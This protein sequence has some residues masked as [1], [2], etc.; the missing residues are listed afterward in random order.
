[1]LQSDRKRDDV[2]VA[3]GDGGSSKGYKSVQKNFSER[4]FF[5]I[6]EFNLIVNQ[7]SIIR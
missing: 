3:G 5:A 1:M 6:S 2:S 7:C 4:Y